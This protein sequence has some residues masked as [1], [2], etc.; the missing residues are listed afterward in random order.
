MCLA[1]VVYLEA[2]GESYE[3]QIAVAEV[4]MNRVKSE[5]Y[6]DTACDVIMQQGQFVYREGLESILTGTISYE[7]AYEVMT[8]GS[9]LTG[10]ATYFHT[11]EVNPYWSD[12]FEYTVTIGNHVFYKE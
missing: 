8:C 6:P 1:T 12:D 3:G 7:A 10:G 4:V 2:R 5:N 11:T 9:D